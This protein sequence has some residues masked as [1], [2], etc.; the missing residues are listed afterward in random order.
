MTSALDT[1]AIVTPAKAYTAFSSVVCGEGAANASG[2]IPIATGNW[3][4]GAFGGNLYCKF[5]VQLIAVSLCGGVSLTYCLVGRDTIRDRQDLERVYNDIVVKNW[6]PKKVYNA[7]SRYRGGEYSS[8]M[9]KFVL[10][11]FG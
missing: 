8:E 6:G 4:Y 11:T 7:M 10:E 5:L 2:T 9:K 1:T 3:G